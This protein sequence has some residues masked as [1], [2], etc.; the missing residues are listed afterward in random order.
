MFLMGKIKKKGSSQKEIKE[1]S[2]YENPK[3]Q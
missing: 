2:D 1:G 3:L